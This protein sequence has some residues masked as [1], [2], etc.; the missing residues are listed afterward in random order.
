MPQPLRLEVFETPEAL[1]GPALLMPE[2]L[3]DLRLN[4]YERGYVAGWEDGGQQAGN[5]R[6]A[7]RGAV[8]RTAEQLAFTY[9]EARGHVLKAL[10]PLFQAL[11]ETVLPRVARAAVVPLTLEQLMPLAHAAAEAPLLL[12]VPPGWREEFLTALDG[13]VLPP[14][15]IVETDDLAEGQAAFAFGAEETSID[16]THA[17]EAIG[18]AIDAFYRI[19]NEEIRRA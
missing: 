16:L 18:G 3:E 19:Q 7:R 1:E 10:E 13:M 17:A 15:E 5:D 11:I 8:E 12:R 2:E 4:A 6:D 9:H 14:L